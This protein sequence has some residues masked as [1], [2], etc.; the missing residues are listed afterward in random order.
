MKY[1][2]YKIKK[3]SE[4]RY[5]SIRK[6][7]NDI[8]S[9]WKLN[10]VTKKIIIA[11][12]K[13]LDESK[14]SVIMFELV[15]PLEFIEELEKEKENNKEEEVAPAPSQIEHAEV[16]KEEMADELEKLEVDIRTAQHEQN[17][18]LMNIMLDV[19]KFKLH[20]LSMVDY[21]TKCRDKW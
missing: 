17:I 8:D 12:T 14:Y 7:K 9:F 10:N 21:L 3:F 13:E 5:V 6:T 20:D 1:S 16:N 2:E 15:A 11:D 18:K 4:V 19:N